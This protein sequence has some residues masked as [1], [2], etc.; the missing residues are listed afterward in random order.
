MLMFAGVGYIRAM[1][2]VGGYIVQQR[3]QRAVTGAVGVHNL[4]R[5]AHKR[6][7]MRIDTQRIL[8]IF[9]TYRPAEFVLVEFSNSPRQ[10]RMLR[11]PFGII[12]G[13]ARHIQPGRPGGAQHQIDPIQCFIC[14]LQ[15]VAQSGQCFRLFF[16]HRQN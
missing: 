3:G 10:Q 9:K 4:L 11:F 12:F 6:R 7:N 8:T 2:G 15:R 16:I 1:V 13:E 14:G 5:P